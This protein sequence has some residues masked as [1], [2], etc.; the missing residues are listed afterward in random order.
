MEI[1][2][3]ETAIKQIK[4]LKKLNLRDVEECTK[5]LITDEN[6]KQTLQ[7]AVLESEEISPLLTSFYEPEFNVT[8]SLIIN[9]A[10]R[11]AMIN[12]VQRGNHMNL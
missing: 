1:S 10:T 6:F 8:I 4:R 5:F 12:G 7:Q 3:S 9:P 11:N 2:F